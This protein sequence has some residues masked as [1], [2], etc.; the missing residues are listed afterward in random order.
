MSR[1]QCFKE[2]MRL[3]EDANGDDMKL[4]CVQ[5]K[6][7]QHAAH[8]SLCDIDVP[9]K[10]RGRDALIRHSSRK[11]HIA[12]A[13]SHRNE[14]GQLRCTKSNQL[15]IQGS[16]SR[17]SSNSKQEFSFDD[18]VTSAEAIWATGV[19]VSHLPA[20]V[21]NIITPSFPVMFPDSQIALS[22]ACKRTKTS[23]I[24][25]DG[26]G[27]FFRASVENEIRNTAPAYTIEI[28]E[29]TTA[30]HWKQLEILVRYYSEEHKRIVVCHLSSITLGKAQ[31]SVL[32]S[33]IVEVVTPLYPKKLL[34]ISSDGPNV[35][36]ALTKD[37]QT[38]LNPDLINIGTCNIHKVHNAFSAA[39]DNFGDDVEL[40]AI[41]LFQFFKY[42]PGK[43]EE[44][45]T[46]QE[47]LGIKNHVFL[48]H[49]ECR[50]LSLQDVAIRLEEQLPA[51]VHFFRKSKF[52]SEV[53]KQT[54]ERVKRM[55]RILEN[56]LLLVEIQFLKSAMVIFTRITRL[57][58]SETPLIP[59]LHNELSTLVSTLMRRFLKPEVVGKKTGAS[60]YDI[61]INDSRNHL[62]KA[63]IGQEAAATLNGLLSRGKISQR[64]YVEFYAR[65]QKFYARCVSLLL[66]SL[67]LKNTIL[68]DLQ[69]LHPL[70]RQ[71]QWST[72]A[73]RRLAFAIKLIPRE[74]VDQVV[75]EWRQFRAEEL[76]SDGTADL[77][78]DEEDEDHEREDEVDDKDENDHESSDFIHDFW[79]KVFELKTLQGLPKFPNLIHFVKIGLTFAHGNADVERAFS[80]NKLILDSK[81]TKMSDA[82]LNGYK[83]TSSYMAKFD[84][85]PEKLPISKSLLKAVRNSRREYFHRVSQQT[86]S[87]NP[88]KVASVSVNVADDQT[89]H[90]EIE[91]ATSQMRQSDDLRKEAM[92][93]L[94]RGIQTKD[95]NK[96]SAANAILERS[97]DLYKSG[98]KRKSEAEKKL[99][100]K[101]RK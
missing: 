46:V 82:T 91:E 28:D 17:A 5:S 38:Q 53:T 63:D 11:S 64:D 79:S 85:R 43:R 49:V 10:F 78:A 45:E 15:T 57:F 23:R 74:K 99:P 97:N 13:N 86:K 22:F 65:S 70:S 59:I 12:I 41:E 42:S 61:E 89:N 98:E 54:N 47:K 56:K 60:L 50:W 31:A 1:K 88:V 6:H 52:V 7:D 25:S 19:A 93:L 51:I 84:R 9:V 18:K 29:T 69:V 27:P 71:A 100:S 4:W 33:K 26:L 35:M 34:Q 3:G 72:D 30:K 95:F 77:A 94:Q 83:A 81:R 36:K 66:K 32:A 20:N 80:E 2:S 55:L 48:R 39:V 87:D 58:Q 40:L 8:C 96:V 44:F 24:L 92:D 73:V 75:D 67:P 14:T 37:L 68:R 90:K 16:F 101:R 62:T 76:T 21:A